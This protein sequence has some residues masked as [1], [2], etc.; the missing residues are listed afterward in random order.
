MIDIVPDVMM[1][2]GRFSHDHIGIRNQVQECFLN[3]CCYWFAF[4]L[5]TRFAEYE[6]EIVIDTT[7][8]HFGCRI[9]RCVYD[10]TGDVTDM[11]QWQ[12]WD[13][14]DDKTHKKRIEKYCVM[15]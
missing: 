11:Y 14:Y 1:F 13:E 10:I 3:G 2:I 6:P 15:F 4:I 9:Q 12:S 5:K 7:A 8:N